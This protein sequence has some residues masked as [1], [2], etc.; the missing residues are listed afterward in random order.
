[1]LVL[2]KLS[3]ENDKENEKVYEY[4]VMLVVWD[5]V[6][7]VMVIFLLIDGIIFKIGMD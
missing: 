3:F 1:M 7:L 4:S 6:M 5:V 2:L